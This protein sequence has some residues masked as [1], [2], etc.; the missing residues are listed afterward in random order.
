MATFLEL[1]KDL[2]SESGSM[3]PAALTNVTGLTGR[4]AKIVNWVRKAYVNIQNSRRDWGWLV[5]EFNDE[6][7]PG[8]PAYTPASFNLTRFANWATDRD[9]YM[10]VSIYDPA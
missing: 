10:P 6:L 7:I 5:T 8:T 4:P 3:D 9:W 2:A 1:A